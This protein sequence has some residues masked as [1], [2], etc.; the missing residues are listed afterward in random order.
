MQQ[1]W[2]PGRRPTARTRPVQEPAYSVVIAE[3]G[4]SLDAASSALKG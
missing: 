2:A 1:L 4:N 3:T